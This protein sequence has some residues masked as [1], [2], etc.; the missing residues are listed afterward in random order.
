M[1]ENCMWK[2]TMSMSVHNV[3]TR[4]KKMSENV[5][6]EEADSSV[7]SPNRLQIPMSLGLSLLT[8]D[9]EATKHTG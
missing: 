5:A 1:L 6:R 4:S 2:R 8:A 9:S 3:I 7:Y